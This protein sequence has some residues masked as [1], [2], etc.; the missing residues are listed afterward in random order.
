MSE[1]N[2]SLLD[3]PTETKYLIWSFHNRFLM[4]LTMKHPF[5][6]NSVGHSIPLL[7]H[8]P[9][10]WCTSGYT[11]IQPSSTGASVHASLKVLLSFTFTHMYLITSLFV[12]DTI[13]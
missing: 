1:G 7:S 10:T 9:R 4:V 2:K 3:T 5:L 8:P 12:L 6:A 11:L 13:F